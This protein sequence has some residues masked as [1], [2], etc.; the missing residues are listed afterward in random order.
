MPRSCPLLD[1][2][3]RARCQE[4]Y[5]AVSIRLVETRAALKRERAIVRK[6]QQK[7]MAAWRLSLFMANV[8]LILFALSQNTC[9]CAVAFLKQHGEKKGWPSRLDEDLVTIVNDTFLAIDLDAFVGL[10]DA[11]S[12]SN[13]QAMKV[14]VRFRSLYATQCWV[15]GLNQGKG[16]APPSSLVS[17]KIEELQRQYPAFFAYRNLNLPFQSNYRV[18]VHRWRRSFGNRYGSIRRRDA[19][20]EEEMQ[21]KASALVVSAAPYT[22]LRLLPQT[23]FLGPNLTRILEPVRGHFWDPFWVQKWVPWAAPFFDPQNII[24]YWGGSE[25]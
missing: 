22:Q 1:E 24:S 3:A 5:E 23:P 16:I 10:T 17:G 2:G 15:K 21:A 25:K 11:G 13:Q 20:S 6:A 18:M 9:E 4:V 14:A 8:V 7:A 12:S 19:L